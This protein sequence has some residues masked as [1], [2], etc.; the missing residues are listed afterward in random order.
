MTQSS[1]QT[2]VT[3]YHNPRCSKSRE[4]LA[5]LQEHNVTPDVVLYLDTPPDAVMLAQLI[6]Q[7]GFNSARELM[8]TKEERYQQLGLSDTALTET[9]LIQAMVDNPK[10]I[11]RPIVVAH[12]Q[13]R[14]GRPPEQVLEIL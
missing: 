9:Q 1:T 4:T 2:S 10:L 8:R 3:I 11:E 7:L 12:G 13:A 5:L 6:Q 14:I